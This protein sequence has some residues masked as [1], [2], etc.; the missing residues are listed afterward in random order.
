MG[1]GGVKVYL[2]GSPP[3]GQVLR[4]PRTVQVLPHVGLLESGLEEDPHYVLAG[5]DP[6]QEER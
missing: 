6:G 4:G 5:T 2:R 1:G 3:P